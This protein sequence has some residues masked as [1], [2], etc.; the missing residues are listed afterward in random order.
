MIGYIYLTTCLVTN[1]IYIGQHKATQFEPEKYLGSGSILHKSINK[2]GKENFTCKLLEEC[3]TQNE[4]DMKEIYWIKYYDSTNPLIGYNILKGG[5]GSYHNDITKDKI[6]KSNKG[7]YLGWVHINLN[8]TEEKIIKPEELDYYLSLG[9]VKGRTNKSIENVKN[10]LKDPSKHQGMKGKKQSEYH[11]QRCLESHLGI[12]L[13]D[14]SRKNMSLGKLGKILI[15]NDLTKDSFYILPEQLEKY[16]N[17]GYHQ[18]RPS[19]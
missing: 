3:N 9:W 10:S 12:K 2:Y 15:S 19:K 13:R 16:L 4:L 7:K 5:S 1:K 8:D 6:S 18:G 17:L 14:E 11:R